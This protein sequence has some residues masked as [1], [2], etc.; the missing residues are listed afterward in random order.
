MAVTALTYNL[1]LLRKLVIRYLCLPRIFPL[2]YVSE[3]D[4]KT[5]RIKHQ[6]YLKEP[7]YNEA[8]IWNRWNPL[9]LITWASGGMIPGDGGAEMKPEGFLFEDLGP[10]Q[11]M[12]KG[13]EEAKVLE[14]RVKK[15]GTGACPFAFT[16]A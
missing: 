15:T 9:A 4:K 2:Q 7:W 3:P 10:L 6:H 1:L 12:G 13:I 16:S 8:T 11:Y 14:D 5:E